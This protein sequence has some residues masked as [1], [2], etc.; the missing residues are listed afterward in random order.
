MQFVD[1]KSQQ[2]RIRANLEKRLLEVLDHGRYIFGPEIEE[3]EQKLADY[4]GV[5]HAT[6]CASGT[7]AL[8]MALMTQEIGPGDAV[9]TTPFTFCATAE[10]ICLLGATPIFVDI[11]DITFNIAPSKLESAIKAVLTNDR[12]YPGLRSQHEDETLTPKA[13]IPVDLFGQPAD[14]DA[15]L[16]IAAKYNFFIIEDAAQSFGAAYKGKKACGL[17]DIGCTSFFPSKPLGC[18]GDGGMCFTDRDDIIDILHSIRIH[19]QGADKNNNV[20]LGINGRMDSF[21]AAVLLEKL[22]IFDEELIL[23][24]KIANNYINIIDDENGLQLPSVIGGRTSTWAQYSI[25]ASSKNHR[26]ICLNQLREDGIP[27]AVY[28]PIPL[29]L[30]GAFRGLDY[31]PGDFPVSEKCAERIFSIPMHPYLVGEEQRIITD[32]IDRAQS[33]F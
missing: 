14:Y 30:Q 19:G 4:V 7:D 8:L 26:E 1:L 28:Y 11:D 17:G 5:K 22:K 32:S 6:A 25:L 18:Y 2:K 10:V 3:L 24:D 9:F 33:F 20:R 23:R 16:S 31:V 29:H 13:V 12:S 15:I 21:Q 27:T